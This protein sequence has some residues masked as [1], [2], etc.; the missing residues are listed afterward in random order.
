MAD[1]EDEPGDGAPE[2]LKMSPEELADR[3]ATFNGFLKA[4]A[5]VAVISVLILIVLAIFRT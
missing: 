2:D 4:A 5:I 3:E 1:K